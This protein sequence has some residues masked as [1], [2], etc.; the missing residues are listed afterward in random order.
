MSESAIADFVSTFNSDRMTS[1]EPVKGRVLLSRKRLV[2]AVNDDD[3]LTI[4]LSSIFDVAV[5]HVPEDLDGFFQSTVTVAFEEQGQQFI[6]VIEGGDGKIGKFSTL[7][8]KAILNGTDATIKHPV[9]VG[10]R[11]TD[12][13]FV[14]AK[15]TL[16]PQRVQFKTGDGTVDV[17]LAAVTEFRRTEREI[18]GA[19]RPVLQV[20]HMP[21][22][23][24]MLTMAATSSSR[25]MSIL[26][27]YLR[28]EYSDLMAE[29]EELE[30]STDEKE[31][32]VAIYSGAGNEGISLPQIVDKDPPKVTLTLNRLEEDELVVDAADGTKLTPKGQVV[33]NKHLEDVNV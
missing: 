9:R 8:F 22:G 16:K 23:E 27:R 14:P 4:P 6:A 5:G 20:R 19:T 32:L 2:L 13:E 12:A 17:S 24:S 29:L 25:K 1:A 21:E 7:L 26:G 10:G 3:K 18:A 11:V 31:L 33:V 30:I 15:L 28:L